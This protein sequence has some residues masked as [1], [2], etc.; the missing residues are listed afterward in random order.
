MHNAT[1]N[2]ES[3]CRF[4]GGPGGSVCCVRVYICAIG[5]ENFKKAIL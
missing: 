4:G 1:V 2:K 3:L 5:Y